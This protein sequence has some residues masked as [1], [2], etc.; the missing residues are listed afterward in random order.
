M[1][2]SQT[3]KT[4]QVILPV[5]ARF[6][7]GMGDRGGLYLFAGP[8]LGFNVGDS[9][10]KFLETVGEWSVNSSNFSVNIGAGI[11]FGSFQ[12]SVN[13]NAALGNTGEVKEK[14]F[15]ENYQ[16]TV[17]TWDSKYNAWQMALAYY[18]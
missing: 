7:F 6:S 16:Q 10:K 1:P 13:Y 2:L 9:D 12:I 8:Q 11:Q 4:Q 14:S 3:I 5:N 18:F 17:D 15:S